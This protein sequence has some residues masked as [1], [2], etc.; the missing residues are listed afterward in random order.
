MRILKTQLKLKW[1]PRDKPRATDIFPLSKRRN[2]KSNLTEIK[3][4]APTNWHRNPR[5][6]HVAC[7]KFSRHVSFY[8][9]FED[10]LFLSSILKIC[11]K[12]LNKKFI[13]I[14]STL[15]CYLSFK[16]VFLVKIRGPQ[17]ASAIRVPF[18][19][20]SPFSPL[21]WFPSKRI[22]PKN[23]NNP[24][25]LGNPQLQLECPRSSLFPTSMSR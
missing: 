23:K 8:W 6:G 14:K 22:F 4:P 20:M 21:S 17:K 3:S 16:L 19:Q 1:F 25:Y 10:D 18:S 2:P 12:L 15:D 9:N 13:S 7:S 11:L 5:L 24:L